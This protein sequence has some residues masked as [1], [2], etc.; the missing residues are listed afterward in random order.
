MLRHISLRSIWSIAGIVLD[1][2]CLCASPIA[3]RP[4]RPSCWNLTSMTLLLLQL[5][6]LEP[7]ASKDS[8]APVLQDPVGSTVQLRRS[9][10]LPAPGTTPRE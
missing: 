10:R 9:W 6:M 3:I 7:P 4:G 2:L 8:T 5:G 1:W